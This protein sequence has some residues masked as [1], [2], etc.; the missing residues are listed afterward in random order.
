MKKVA[1]IQKDLNHVVQE[2]SRLAALN[3]STVAQGPKYC[4][5][6]CQMK[7]LYTMIDESIPM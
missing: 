1:R 4:S 5:T 6:M 3:D 7:L 2:G